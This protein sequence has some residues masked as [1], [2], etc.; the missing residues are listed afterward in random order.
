MQEDLVDFYVAARSV[1]IDR[2]YQAEREW[3]EERIYLQFSETDLLREG[4]WV[5]LNTGFKER[6]IRRVFSYISL[7]FCDWE[8]AFE[9]N[10]NREI[11]RE[12]TLEAFGNHRKVDAILRMSEMIEEHGFEN[13]K[14]GITNEPREYLQIFPMIGNI[15]AS[16]L[17]KNLGF[18]LAKADRHL[19]RIA[20]EHG[21]DSV[22]SLCE[23][24]SSSVKEGVAVVDITLW[25]YSVLRAEIRN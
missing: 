23:A 12:L 8:S 6:Y 5:I 17:A 13:I 25:R 22:A 14:S 4:A 16:H 9:I 24:I 7:C 10:R 3:Q 2:G 20:R 21:Y 18:S 15:T 1:V 11:C 19:V